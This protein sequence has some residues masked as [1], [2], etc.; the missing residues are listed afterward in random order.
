MVWGACSSDL[1]VWCVVHLWGACSSDLH[2]W[3]G[4]HVHLIYMRTIAVSR[5]CNRKLWWCRLQ[6][7]VPGP[8]YFS[9]FVLFNLP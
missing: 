8:P 7:T 5:A 6:R 9:E 2:V 4:V 3:C 1:H